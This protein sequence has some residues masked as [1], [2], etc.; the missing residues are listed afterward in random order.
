MPGKNH[1]K[2]LG[3]QL[4]IRTLLSPLRVRTIVLANYIEDVKHVTDV[5]A[6]HNLF[7]SMDQ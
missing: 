1:Q 5:P 2:S 6:G 7:E 4:N 3:T